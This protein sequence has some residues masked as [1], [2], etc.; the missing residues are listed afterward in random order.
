MARSNSTRTGFTLIELMIVV[1]ILG[2]LAAI[3]VP[4]FITYIRRA[5]ASEANDAL[6]QIFN[7]AA[8]YFSRELMG[9]G[10][11]S[12][13]YFWC[14]VGTTDN[15]ITPTATRQAGVYTAAPWEAL[16]FR[17]GASYY[18]YEIDNGVVAAGGCS[19]PAGSQRVYSLRARGNLDDDE[20]SS[21][22]ELTVGTS[23]D[24]ELFHAPGFYEELLLE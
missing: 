2:I 24:N 20:T 18:R 17:H 16:G 4:S 22:I 5:K 1:A 15:G 10:M 9:S 12:A 3:A 13:H 8:A 7:H 11:T 14:T 21:L 6:K 19:T 23:A